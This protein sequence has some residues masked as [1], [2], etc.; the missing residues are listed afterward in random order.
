VLAVGR[1]F[2]IVQLAA[3]AS[4]FDR[5]AMPPMLATIARSFDVSLAAVAIAASVYFLLYG[6]VQPAWGMIADRV[7][8]IRLMQLGLL[9]SAAAGAVSAAAPSLT[10]LA[11]ARGVSGAFVGAVVPLSIIYVGDTVRPQTRQR[12]VAS[13]MTATGTGTA[14]GTVVGGALAAWVSWRAGFALGAAMALLLV[15]PLGRVSEPERHPKTESPFAQLRVLG[16]SPWALLVVVL[17]LTEGIIAFGGIPFLAPSVEATGK[18]A[19]VAGLT[20]AAFGLAQVVWTQAVRRAVARVH[21]PGLMVLG[22]CTFSG[23]YAAAAAWPGVAG[24]AIA[25]CLVAGGYACFHTGLLAWATE[26][27]PEARAVTVSFFGAALFVGTAISTA[28]F[29]PLAAD[30][31]YS[32]LFTV[33]ALGSLPLGLLAATARRRWPGRNEELLV[34]PA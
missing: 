19:A 25:A 30:H 32:L 18:T 15:L 31:R 20:V 9:V 10:V 23:G 1:D 2:R 14:A 27:L 17:A 28:A 34:E 11:I 7:G 8:R 26:V 12:A 6:L 24:V 13:L 3:F 16:R 21:A 4:I 33:C 22:G 5:Y 29:G